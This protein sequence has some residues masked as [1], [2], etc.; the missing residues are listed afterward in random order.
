MTGR[1]AINPQSE[2]LVTNGR[3]G[4]YCG[5][6]SGEVRRKWHGFWGAENPPRRRR[7]LIAGF[8]EVLTNGDRQHRLSAHWQGGA[9]KP[10]DLAPAESARA[11]TRWNLPGGGSLE[12]EFRMPTGSR[13]QLL[14]VYTLS[15]VDAAAGASVAI[16]PILP[17]EGA[18]AALRVRVGAGAD[19][20]IPAGTALNDVELAIERDCE[21]KWTGEFVRAGGIRVPLEA[22]RARTVLF[23]TNHRDDSLD[24]RTMHGESPAA[25]DEMTL[26]ADQ[27]IVRGADDHATILAG[28][29]WF[30]DWGRDAMISIPGLCLCTGRVAEAREIVEHFLRHLKQGLIPN[31]FPEGDEPPRYN[32]VD[33]TLWLVEMMF[34][35]WSIEGLRARKDLWQKLREIITG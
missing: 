7:L 26:A 20:G 4:F 3:G 31:L 34:R 16:H 29:P 12:R 9:W 35:L 15:G 21:K 5:T 30:T 10:A 32:T 25:R 28:Y 8:E 24:E 11:R 19:S 27:F 14:I 17:A 6:V 2:L 13:E 18:A 23:H 1:R 22:G 33:A